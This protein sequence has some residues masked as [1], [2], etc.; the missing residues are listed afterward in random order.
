[1]SYQTG[2]GVE[3]PKSGG[4]Y[5]RLKDK[6]EKVRLRL[7]SEP[8][9]FQDVLPGKGEDGGDKIV[10]KT[11]WLAIHKFTEGGKPTKKVVCFQSGP[12]VYGLVKDLAE[13]PDWGDPKL[14]D[15]EVTRTEEKGKYYTVLPKNKPIGPISEEEAQLVADANLDLV[16][17][18]IKD[19]AS[20]V[21]ASESE[22]EAPDPFE[23]DD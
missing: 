2:Y 17:L 10:N 3:V 14:Y 19:N 18:C 7:V 13:D 22:S 8:I 6:G 23:D 15:I 5:L 12:M 21:N 1:M 20:P 11:A 9:H 4:I 16:K